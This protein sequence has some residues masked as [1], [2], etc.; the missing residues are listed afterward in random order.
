MCSVAAE[1]KNA[2]SGRVNPALLDRA[3][4]CSAAAEENLLGA[5]EQCFAR[6]SLGK[7]V[8]RRPGIFCSVPASRIPFCM[9]EQFFCPAT[10]SQNPL[11]PAEHF[12]LG[13][14][15]AETR[16]GGSGAF[17]C[18]GGAVAGKYSGRPEQKNAPIGSFRKSQ[19]G[20]RFQFCWPRF[21]TCASMPTDFSSVFP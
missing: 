20:E 8:Q 3:F 19:G 13:S 9:A 14:L 5:A 11:G 17:F 21:W 1:Q 6:P 18:S 10:P 15:P 12:L 7:I 4:Y 2:R 16:A